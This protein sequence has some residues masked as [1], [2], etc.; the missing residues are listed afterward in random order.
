MNK[1]Q[2][3][4]KYCKTS[5][6]LSEFYKGKNGVRSYCK[7]CT[8]A[9]ALVRANNFKQ[10]CV[11]YKGGQCE[12]CGYNKYIG[13]LQFHHHNPAKKDSQISKL[14]SYSFNDSVKKELDKCQLLCCNCHQEVHYKF[15][16]YKAY[17][18][19]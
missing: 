1:K 11:E 9:E 13:A 6:P 5:K 8:R 14:T 18:R 3:Y 2:K 7:P 4:C 12:I 10:K 15:N 19:K 16:Q 17:K